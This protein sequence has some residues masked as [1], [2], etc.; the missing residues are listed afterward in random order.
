MNSSI[1]HKCAPSKCTKLDFLE[2]ND[3]DLHAH[4]LRDWQQQYDQIGAGR[5]YGSIRELQLQDIQVFREHTSQALR[6]SCNVW[7]N[8]IWIGLPVEPRNHVRIN[9]M[10]IEE[11]HIMCRPGDV[12]FELITPE[13]FDIF[14]LVISHQKLVD[15]AELQ[16]ININWADLINEGR[17]SIPN[18]TMQAIRIVL[19]RLLTP[20]RLHMPEKLSHDMIMMSIL[21]ILQKESPASQQKSSHQRRKAVVDTAKEFLNAHRDH[22]VSIAD[23]CKIC[24]VSRRTLQYSFDS[25]LG[26]SPLQYLRIS[27]LNGVRRTIHDKGNNQHI[28]EVAAQWGFWHLS[29]FSHDY[30]QLFGELPSQTQQKFTVNQF[31]I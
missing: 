21:E 24:H 16:N 19:Q 13:D 22:P 12:D 8:A 17:L 10:N 29:Q 2:A 5:F 27:R 28:A 11:N 4:N 26:I 14:G 6:Q 3:A 23:L 18:D 15:N 9:G 1:T 31:N 7:S 25:I 30:K 20:G